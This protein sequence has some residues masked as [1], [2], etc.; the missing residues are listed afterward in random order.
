VQTDEDDLFNE[1][2]HVKNVVINRIEEWNNVN[3]EVDKKR[4]YVFQVL[5]SKYIQYRN[6]QVVVSFPLPVSGTK[7]AVE[8]IF[9]NC[10]IHE[11]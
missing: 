7:T 10:E 6:I 5:Q 11:N 9:F 8:R 3:N 1:I 2:T 4:C